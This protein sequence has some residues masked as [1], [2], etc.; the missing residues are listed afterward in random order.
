MKLYEKFEKEF[1]EMLNLV[2]VQTGISER[3]RV[4]DFIEKEII[5]ELINDIQSNPDTNKDWDKYSFKLWIESKQ[6]QLRKKWL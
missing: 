5:T 6:R 3:L 2:E 4:K 1:S